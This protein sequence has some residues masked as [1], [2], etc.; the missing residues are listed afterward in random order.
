MSYNNSKTYSNLALSNT[1]DSV[2]TAKNKKLIS[3]AIYNPSNAAAFI[4]F[5][6]AL[7]A[8]VT[9]G[10]T[11]PEFVIGIPTVRELVALIGPANFET[12]IVVAATTT[13][14]GSSAPSAALQVALFYA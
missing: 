14:T 8:D 1:K 5:F 3:V 4:Q 7:A 9:V 10:T 12:G 2:T 11:T 6:D 13:A